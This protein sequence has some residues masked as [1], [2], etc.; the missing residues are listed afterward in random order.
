[1][2]NKF[3]IFIFISILSIFYQN[4]S[5]SKS[6]SF[7]NFNSKDF[8]NYFSGIVAF[9]NRSNLEA[10]KFFNLSKALLDEHD[11]YL[12]RYITTLILENDISKAINVVKNN[13][14]QNNTDF[15][16]AHLLLILDSLKKK[17]SIKLI[18]IQNQRQIF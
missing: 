14:E 18:Y 13:F 9:E 5:H 4:H 8:S 1:M 7:Y 2:F 16:E 6:T 10:L 15:F 11:P 17:I 3:F 12:K